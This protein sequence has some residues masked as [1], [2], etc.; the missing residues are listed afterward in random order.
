MSIQDL[1][2]IGEL[3]AALATIVTLLYLALQI[4][5]NTIS[6]QSASFHSISDSMN[7]INM[8]VAQNP[9]LC[10]LWISGCTDRKALSDGERHQLDLIL[11]SYLH[12]FETMYYQANLGTGDSNL[13]TTEERSLKALLANAGVR[14][15]WSDNPYA[16]S[17]DFRGYVETFLPTDV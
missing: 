10:R 11:L 2:S 4:R 3:L 5:R 17:Q 1:G 13:V 6:T 8:S 14:E 9:E 16:F 12:V 7:H 15:W